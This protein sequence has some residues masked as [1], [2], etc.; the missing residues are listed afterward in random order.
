MWVGLCEV[1]TLG[2]V[3]RFAGRI[4][5]LVVLGRARM[6]DEACD[7]FTGCMPR[8]LSAQASAYGV[9]RATCPRKPMGGEYSLSLVLSSADGGMGGHYCSGAHGV[10]MFGLYASMCGKHVSYG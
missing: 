9:C 7:P 3:G 5:L 4:S 10:R 6:K 1:L 8:I 2:F